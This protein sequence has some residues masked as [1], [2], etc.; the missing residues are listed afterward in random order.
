MRLPDADGDG[1]LSESWDRCTVG[2]DKEVVVALTYCC[3]SWRCR[4]NADRG[5]GVDEVVGTAFPV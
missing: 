2:R 3:F 4:V 1:S 5:S